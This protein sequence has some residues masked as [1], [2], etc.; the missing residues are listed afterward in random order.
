MITLNLTLSHEG[1]YAFYGKKR[2]AF[3]CATF[4]GSEIQS[5]PKSITLQ[6][7]RISFPHSSNVMVKHDCCHWWW[8]DDYSVRNRAMYPKMEEIMESLSNGDR[9]FDVFYRITTA[10]K[11]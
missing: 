10:K 11:K 8:S 1:P 2:S 3:I 7:N 4:V 5:W 6:I 9:E